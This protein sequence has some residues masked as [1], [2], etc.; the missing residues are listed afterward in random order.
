MWEARTHDAYL[1]YLIQLE[2]V[3]VSFNFDSIYFLGDFNADPS[4]GRAWSN[5]CS[6]MSRNSLDCFDFKIL[7]SSTFTFI[8]YSNSY[9]KWLD[10]IVGR[11]TEH[12]N[13][14]RASVLYDIVGSDHLPLSFT[15]HI[16]INKDNNGNF[17][18]Q[19]D[20][21]LFK[22]VDWNNLPEKEI[23]DIEHKALRILER[24]IPYEATHCFKLGCRD[25]KH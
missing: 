12:I 8:S 2:H 16:S 4:S 5:L 25:K 23:E 19:N 18:P 17:Y 13:T 11:G 14:S 15:L 10:H 6:F 21:K 3:I 9:T 1:E 7:D 20:D 22:Y 24:V